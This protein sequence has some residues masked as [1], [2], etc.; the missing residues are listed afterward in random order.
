M[1][2]NGTKSG[3]KLALLVIEDNDE[4]IERFRFALD[5]MQVSSS[6]QVTFAR[7]RDV[8]NVLLQTRRFHIV[9][10]DLYMPPEDGAVSETLVS[11]G[12]RLF[13]E[14]PPRMSTALF[15]TGFPKESFGLRA[16]RLAGKRAILYLAKGAAPNFNRYPPEASVNAWAAVIAT[17]AGAPLGGSAELRVDMQAFVDG[18]R[19]DPEHA[20]LMHP[21]FQSYWLRATRELPWPLAREAA[22]LERAASAQR[23]GASAVLACDRFRIW[24]MVLA[25]AQMAAFARALGQTWPAPP[26][27]SG[28]SQALLAL[29][30]G[31]SRDFPKLS[32][33]LRAIPAWHMSLGGHPE[34]RNAGIQPFLDGLAM[35]RRLRNNSV[36]SL[37]SQPTHR[38]ADFESALM[39]LMD[40]AGYWGD[41]PW[42]I[43]LRLEHGRWVGDR[44]VGDS[45]RI[46]DEKLPDAFAARA[47]E[48]DHVVQLCWRPESSTSAAGSS[49]LRPL[50]VDAWPWLRRVR[51]PQGPDVA[52]LWVPLA[53]PY[54]GSQRWRAHTFGGESLDLEVA[55]A[56]FEVRNTSSS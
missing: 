21:W 15:F 12:E 56:D 1:N 37:K 45:E 35:T 55:L 20:E 7:S 19:K 43:N 47:P 6:V 18:L 14:F 42:L 8:A 30:D 52:A 13:R 27:I 41:Y 5:A 54:R 33:L 9:S 25:R 3:H 36:H 22:L 34:S 17:L 28:E 23:W 48:S 2:A 26:F 31:I 50:L 53:P 51:S 16:A 11:A 40:A 38:S 39:P 10:S 32:D 46:W 24:A 29:E 49:P 4:Q 44:L